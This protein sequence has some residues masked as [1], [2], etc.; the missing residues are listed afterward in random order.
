MNYSFEVSHPPPPLPPPSLYCVCTYDVCRKSCISV[1]CTQTVKGISVYV[2]VYTSIP[3]LAEDFF[4]HLLSRSRQIIECLLFDLKRIR[5]RIRIHLLARRNLLWDIL[6]LPSSRRAALC[7]YVILH[8]MMST[9]CEPTTICI[10][11]TGDP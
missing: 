8:A 3:T 9:G 6:K 4:I 10:A 1:I 2:I 5:K 7:L 11:A